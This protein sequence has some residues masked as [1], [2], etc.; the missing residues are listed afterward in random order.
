FEGWKQVAAAVLGLL[1]V[2]LL[3]RRAFW[4]MAWGLVSGTAYQLL[5]LVIQRPRPPASLVHVFR[6]TTGYSFP[7]GHLVF[8]TWFG[9]YLILV[10]GGR[11]PRFVKTLLWA[12]Y[13]LLLATVSVSRVYTA[14]HWPTDVLAGLLLGGAWTLFGL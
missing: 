12:L 13:G 5:E 11:L 9:A 10:F 14:E 1:L 7:S 4:L 2:Y 8:L 6:H 3:R